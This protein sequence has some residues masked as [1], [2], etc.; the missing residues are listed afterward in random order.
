MT[1]RA[2]LI[3]IEGADGVGKTSLVSA[4]KLL[5]PPSSV[6][7]KYPDFSSSI[8]N[9]IAAKSRDS[10]AHR[11]TVACLFAASFY[12]M[13]AHL[14]EALFTS[15]IVVCDRF[16]ASFMAYGM[17][18][19]S[20]PNW[21]GNVLNNI[22]NPDLTIYLAAPISFASKQWKGDL[23]ETYGLQKR[24]HE[25]YEAL[26]KVNTSSWRQIVVNETTPLETVVKKVHTVI[27]DYTHQVELQSQLRHNLN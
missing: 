9:L 3:A 20:N 17:A 19:G 22:D 27:T 7:L 6:Y 12:E 21:L 1:N 16:K 15:P 11:R 25:A 23:N 2:F 18:S 5:L 4:L 13:D 8:G 14:R 24:V 10:E 26:Y